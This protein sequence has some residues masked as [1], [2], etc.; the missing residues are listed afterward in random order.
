MTCIF[1]ATLPFRIGID[2]SCWANGRGYGRFTRELVSAMVA[3]APS[4]EFVCFMDA[5]AAELFDLDAPNVRQVVVPQGRSP[6]EA[7]ADGSSRS[8]LDML[9]MTRAVLAERLD[10]FFSPTIYTY[11]PLPPRLRAVVT[12]HDTIV[13]R[14]PALTIPD[15]RARFFWSAKVRLAILQARSILTVSQYAADEISTVLAVSPH[16]IRVATE[17]P[18]DQY[19][20]TP[21]RTRAL[22]ASR[23]AGVPVGRAWITYVGG[24]NPHKHVDCLVEAVGRVAAT[25]PDAPCLLL[26]G[27]FDDVFHGAQHAIRSA[28]EASGIGHLV[29]WPGFVADDELRHLHA[30]A[31]ALALPSASEGFGLPAVEAAACGAPVIATT[32]SPLPQLLA[33]GGIFVAPGDVGAIASAITMMLDDEPARAAMG[34]IARERALALTW[35]ASARAALDAIHE[36]AR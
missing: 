20:Q 17:A 11:F 12:I 19:R 4:D 29:K 7:A 10:V 16:K 1:G 8:P 23:R 25:R 28:I 21:D 6:T 30:G 24:F 9:R 3:R 2:T 26:V 5:R 34:R 15:R 33:G 27:G 14:F 18:A 31:L 36:A 22:D 32:A 35:D 13:E